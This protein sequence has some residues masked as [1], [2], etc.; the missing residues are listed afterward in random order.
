MIKIFKLIFLVILIFLSCIFWGCQGKIDKARELIN[1]NNYDEAEQILIQIKSTDDE[2]N[3]AQ[4]LLKVIRYNKS[5]ELIKSNKISKAID[6]LKDFNQNDTLYKNAK[7]LLAYCEG[8]QAYKTDNLQEAYNEFLKIDKDCDFYSDA[9]AKLAELK[10]KISQN[11]KIKLVEISEKFRGAYSIQNFKYDIGAMKKY[12]D[13][14]NSLFSETSNDDI[15]DG[16]QM[17]INGMNKILSLYSKRDNI[18]YLGIAGERVWIGKM[19][20][21]DALIIKGQKILKGN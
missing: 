10:E 19:E 11:I 1:K 17:I 4:N 5:I 14:F 2:Y 18:E 6:I 20:D 15:K 7:S 21:A 13:E 8:M 9:Q 3:A 16:S 12:R